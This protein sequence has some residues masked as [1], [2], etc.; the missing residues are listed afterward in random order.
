MKILTSKIKRKGQRSLTVLACLLI[1]I[2]CQKDD[3]NDV[4]SDIGEPQLNE[5]ILTEN[6]DIIDCTTIA[7]WDQFAVYKD[8]DQVNYKDQVFEVDGD[9][10]IH[11]GA[12]SKTSEKGI[13]V[14]SFDNDSNSDLMF[15]DGEKQETIISET[16]RFSIGNMIRLQVVDAKTIEV[17][18]FAPMDL[19]DITVMATIQGFDNPIALFKID[20]LRAHAIQTVE[21]PFLKGDFLYLD[22]KGEATDLTQFIENGIPTDQIKLDFTGDDKIIQTLLSFRQLN[23]SIKFYDF[24]PENDPNDDEQD[25]IKAIDAR[26]YTAM[27]INYAYLQLRPEFK[28]GFMNQPITENDESLMSNDRK[29]EVFDQLINRK[30]YSALKVLDGGSVLGLGGGN[31]FGV[32]NFTL[33]GHFEGKGYY[34][35]IHEASHGLSFNHSSNMTYPDSEGFGITPVADRLAEIITDTNEW[36]ITKETYYLQSDFTQLRIVSNSLVCANKI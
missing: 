26:K 22:S 36:P 2:S 35:M 23:W 13:A 4:Q 1:L 20:K 27:F 16:R 17:A 21:Y 15:Q 31:R 28:E 18:N 25:D 10:W 9:E 30:Y 34:V 14:Y 24:D 32:N 5:A 12:C 29:I 8:G 3:N 7:N 11:L 6:T 19:K 33:N